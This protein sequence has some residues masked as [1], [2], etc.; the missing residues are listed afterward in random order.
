MGL[1]FVLSAIDNKM[2]SLFMARNEKR[3]GEVSY[4]SHKANNFRFELC[5]LF[6]YAFLEVGD[7]QL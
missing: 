1:T 4:R 6:C 3:D 5:I 7:Q 2:N